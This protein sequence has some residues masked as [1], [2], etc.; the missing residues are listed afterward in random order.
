MSKLPKEVVIKLEEM[1]GPT[2][3]WSVQLLQKNLQAHLTARENAER[4]RRT[5][6]PQNVA[7]TNKFTTSPKRSS[8]EALIAGAS[9]KASYLQNQQSSRKS[10]PTAKKTTGMTSV[11]SRRLSRNERKR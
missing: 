5:Y 6:L 11:A 10:V 2:E 3:V 7:S 9:S 1:K 4:Q 8:A